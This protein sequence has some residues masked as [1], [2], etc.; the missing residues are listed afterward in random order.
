M[1]AALTGAGVPVLGLLVYRDPAVPPP[2]DEDAE[3]DAV[4]EG[5]EGRDVERV[6]PLEADG[7]LGGDVGEGD[8]DKRHG[9]EQPEGEISALS[10]HFWVVALSSMPIRQ[11]QVMSTIH[12]HAHQRHR[13]AR[14]PPT[15]SRRAG[16]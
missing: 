5:V 4:D 3:Q 14:R 15:A 16:R 13:P 9:R 8:L 2:V 10:S 11:I 1:T 6:E 12:R 7:G